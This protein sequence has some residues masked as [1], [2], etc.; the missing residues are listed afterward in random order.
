MFAIDIKFKHDTFKLDWIEMYH[1]QR[2]ECINDNVCIMTKM[3]VM[4]SKRWT[5]NDP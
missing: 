5:V 4:T 2:V 3:S 1:Y